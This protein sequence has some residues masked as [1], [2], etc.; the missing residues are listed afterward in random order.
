MTKYRCLSCGGEYDPDQPGGYYHAC[1]EGTKDP[2]DENLDD[3][4]PDKPIRPR[5]KGK[6]RVPAVEEVIA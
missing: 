2:R 6:G 4:R 3:S 1:P 5:K